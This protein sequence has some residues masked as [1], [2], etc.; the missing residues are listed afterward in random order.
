MATLRIEPISLFFDFFAEMRG[1]WSITQADLNRFVIQTSYISI[2]IN[3]SE[4]PASWSEASDGHVTSIEVWDRGTPLI[5]VSDLDVTFGSIVAAYNQSSGMNTLSF[6]LNGSDTITGG[7]QPDYIV[8]GDGDDRIVLSQG[9]DTIDGGN[10]ADTIDYSIAEAQISGLRISLAGSWAEET[11]GL[12]GAKLHL[13]NIEHAIGSSGGDT[14]DGSAFANRLEGR[15]GNDS[16]N[17]QSGNDT[18]IG[19]DGN[20]TILGGDGADLIQGGAGDD[21]ID[22]GKGFDFVVFNGSLSDYTI[23]V[24]ARGAVTLTD[25]RG[26]DGIDVLTNVEAL[27]FQNTTISFDNLLPLSVAD[28]S[29]REDSPV[30]MQLPL[31]VATL[32]G[33]TIRLAD[34]SDLPDWLS[35]D[36]ASNTLAG[37]PPQNW[38]GELRIRIEGFGDLLTRS[39]EFNLI[40]EPVNDAPVASWPVSL[41]VAENASTGTPVGIISAADVEGHAIRYAMIDDAGGRFTLS[42]DGRSILVADG[43]KLDYEKAATH[44]ITVAVIDSS[45]AATI[46]TLTIQLQDIARE[47]IPARKIKGTSGNDK[48]TGDA[49]REILYGGLGNDTLMGGKG[50]DVFVFD[51]KPN[52]SFNKDKIADFSVKDDAIW[53]DNAVFTKLGKSGSEKKPAQLKKDFFTIGSKAKDKN[54]YLV[55]DDKKG[56]LYYDADGSGSK[57]KQVEIAVLK[58]GLKI[59]VADFFII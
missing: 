40:V 36:P 43:S 11:D 41:R 2:V 35:Y 53:L 13:E 55:Y 52:R 24:D 34:G 23:A 58:T 30:N 46:E 44:R 5:W 1:G 45:G 59:S 16:L 50:Q 37:T 54:D 9:N 31:V 42:A 14:I 25:N 33:L 32:S 22:G 19:G 12:F 3:G 17:G 47:S 4:L 39:G 6:L 49:G 21:S 18:L 51:S 8:A 27:S 10:G 48:L 29:I 20:D 57:Y 26:I 28:M 56:K 7:R 15:D 38:H